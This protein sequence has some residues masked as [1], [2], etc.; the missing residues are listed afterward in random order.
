MVIRESQSNPAPQKEAG[1]NI[2]ARPCT[3]PYRTGSSARMTIPARNR[4]VVDMERGGHEDLD[5]SRA[6]VLGVGSSLWRVLGRDERLRA[7]AIHDSIT[8][9]QCRTRAVAGQAG[10]RN[11]PRSVRG[12][13]GA[14]CYAQR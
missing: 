7:A 13:P 1:V 4:P 3:Q 12:Q 5:V 2:R 14:G 6:V 9:I 8:A 11:C 10:G